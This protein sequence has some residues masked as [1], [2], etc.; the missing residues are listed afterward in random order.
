MQASLGIVNVAYRARVPIVP[1]AYAS[2]RRRVLATWDRR[3]RAAALS[4]GL[5]VAPA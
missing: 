2:S 1:L 3:L 5:A 4:E